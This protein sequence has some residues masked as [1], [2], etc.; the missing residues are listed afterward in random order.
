MGQEISTVIAKR[1]ATQPYLW[2]KFQAWLA[3]PQALALFVVSYDLRGWPRYLNWI[4]CAVCL[5]VWR[6][7]SQKRRYGLVLFYLLALEAYANAAWTI[8]RNLARHDMDLFWLLQSSLFW[9]MMT[10]STILYLIPCTLYYPKR[11]SEFR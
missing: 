3:L 7:L 4:L 9:G 5:I 6:G 10:W 1:A 2:G 8:E 11:W